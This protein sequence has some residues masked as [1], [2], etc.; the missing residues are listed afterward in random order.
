MDQQHGLTLRKRWVALFSSGLGPRITTTLG[1]QLAKTDRIIGRIRSKGC[2]GQHSERQR[3]HFFD[4]IINIFLLQ[5]TEQFPTS[6]G[7]VWLRPLPDGL[8]INARSAG[9]LHDD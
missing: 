9:L 6:V 7:L 1:T 2:N 5:R 8:H 3:H 4:P